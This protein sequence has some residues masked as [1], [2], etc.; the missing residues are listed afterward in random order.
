MQTKTDITVFSSDKIKKK[1]GADLKSQFLKNDLEI[2]DS[3]SYSPIINS[4]D[5]LIGSW[6]PRSGNNPPFQTTDIWVE[7]MKTSAS[8]LARNKIWKYNSSWDL[9]KGRA[10]PLSNLGVYKNIFWYSMAVQDQEPK[11]NQEYY[12][13][14]PIKIIAKYPQCHSLSLGNWWG[15]KTAK[16]IYKMCTENA[17]K[18]LFLP[19]TFGKLTNNAP[20][21]LATRQLYSDPFV[22][23][24]KIEQNDIKLLVYNG[25]PIFGDV[26]LLKSYQIRKA[27]YYF[28]SVDNQEKCVY[29]HPE[30]TT[31]KIDEILGYQKDFPYLTYHA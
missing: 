1:A 19:P 3:V 12:Q 31:D 29:D 23:L 21:L 27:N 24:T 4:Y 28:F 14:F 7:E 15:G 13:S 17:A 11:Q 5:Y 26:N 6:V 16:E 25:K 30:K 2:T 22:N 10:N 18:A 8:Y 20:H 9:T